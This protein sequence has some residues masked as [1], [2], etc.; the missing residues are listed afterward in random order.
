MFPPIVVIYP[1]HMAFLASAELA[2]NNDEDLASS[3][4]ESLGTP[5][6]IPCSPHS[7]SRGPNFE[8]KATA[9]KERK[10]DPKPLAASKQH[11]QL[12]RRR[13]PAQAQN[14]Q[15]SKGQ[16]PRRVPEILATYPASNLAD[17]V[18]EQD[19][20]LGQD[21]LEQR[22]SL[23]RHRLIALLRSAGHSCGKSE[24]ATSLT[25]FQP[26]ASSSSS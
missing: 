12:P 14:Q 6:S 24:R 21:A 23:Q 26:K 19:F 17:G 7:T 18:F 20:H 8:P 1:Q 5:Y 4:K 22:L 13:P 2:S 25:P 11:S 10:T 9:I 3:N 16:E 15:G